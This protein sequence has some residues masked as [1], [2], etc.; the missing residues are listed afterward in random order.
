MDLVF[1]L[2]VALS[3]MYFYRTAAARE[4]V[5]V[6]GKPYVTFG[7]DAYIS[8]RYARNLFEGHGLVWNVGEPPVEGYTNFL[9]VIWIALLMFFSRDPSYLMVISGGVFHLVSV[10]MLY[11]FLRRAQKIHFII[12]CCLA[13]LLAIWQP[14][15]TQ[16]FNALEPPLLLMLFLIA[17]YFLYGSHRSRRGLII[18]SVSAGLLPLVRP[19]GIVL[20]LILFTGILFEDSFSLRNLKEKLART[21]LI[22][23]CFFVPILILTL[24]RLFYYSDLLPNTFYLK[25]FNRP[26]RIEYGWNYVI[27]FLSAFYG[28]FFL[29]PLIAYAA[30][31]EKHWIRALGIGIIVILGY[32][33]YQ[34]GDAWN[35]WRFMIPILP[36]CLLIVGRLIQDSRDHKAFG[37]VAMGIFIVL[38]VSGIWQAFGIFQRGGLYPSIVSSTAENIRLGILLNRVCKSDALIA[39][40]WAGATPSYSNLNTIDMLGKSDRHIARM[41]AQ[42]VGGPPGHDKY[43]IEYALARKPDVIISN[44]PLTTSDKNIQAGLYGDYAFGAKLLTNPLFQREYIPFHS[45]ISDRWQGIFIRRGSTRCDTSKIITEESNILYQ[46]CE[47]KFDGWYPPDKA[48]YVRWSWSSGKGTIK[49]IAP[50]EKLIS[51]TGELASAAVPNTLGVLINGERVYSSQILKLGFQKFETGFTRITPGENIIEFVSGN[52]AVLVNNDKRFLCYAVKSLSLHDSDGI[53]WCELEP[54]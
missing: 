27:S 2:A 7:D 4:T 18:G 31:H 33:A 22:M 37:R 48:G 10:V 42:K 51:L 50:G 1:L 40:F 41:P 43:D 49:F 53:P 26:G 25:V 5:Y 39:D 11:L 45:R 32:I 19:D 47:S 16:V 30:F 24:F 54:R 34:G 14:I 17:I 21:K 15:H 46:Q 36:L 20:T 28:T 35:W 23:L 38:F 29:I 3:M 52:P 8:M 13:F 6:D 44:Y 9:W 12:G